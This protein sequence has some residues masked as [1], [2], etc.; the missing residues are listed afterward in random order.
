M[1]LFLYL[2][3]L[4]ICPVNTE[5]DDLPTLALYVLNALGRGEG[6]GKRLFHQR[7]LREEGDGFLGRILE[8]YWRKL[9]FE[10]L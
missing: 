8:N 3:T 6:G 10:S 9:L 4:I 1:I 7:V 5:F 2:V